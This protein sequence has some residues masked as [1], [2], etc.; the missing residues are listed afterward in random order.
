MGHLQPLVTWRYPGFGMQCS[1][2]CHPSGVAP[3]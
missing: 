1:T 3:R 2:I